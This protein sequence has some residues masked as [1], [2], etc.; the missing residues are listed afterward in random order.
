[1]CDSHPSGVRLTPKLHPVLNYAVH[2][3]YHPSM[4][5]Q[6]LVSSIQ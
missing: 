4:M 3:L 1:M 6:G 5:V 2:V